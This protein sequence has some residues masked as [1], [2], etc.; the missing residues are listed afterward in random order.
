MNY[1]SQSSA[2]ALSGKFTAGVDVRLGS[3]AKGNSAALLL[4]LVEKCVPWR[5]RRLLPTYVTVKRDA[6]ER[7]RMHEAR[8]ARHGLPD[9]RHCTQICSAGSG[10]AAPGDG[11]I[12][13][14]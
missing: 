14:L 8:N 9:R 7:R 2:S 6:S 11:A 5:W 1:V 13:S 4:R 3:S 12:S 10:V